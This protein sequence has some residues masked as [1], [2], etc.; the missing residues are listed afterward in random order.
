MA[1]FYIELTFPTINTSLQEGDTVYYSNLTNNTAN[2]VISVDVEFVGK[3]V[4]IINGNTIKVEIEDQVVFD[5]I[6]TSGLNLYFSFSK[7]NSVNL[8]SLKGYYAEVSFTNNSTEKAELFSVG[9][10]IQQSSK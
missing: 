9:A 3:I 7:D 6:L 8:S 1:L 2:T 4:E 5:Y 10:E